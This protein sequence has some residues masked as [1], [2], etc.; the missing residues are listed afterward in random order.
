MIVYSRRRGRKLI[1]MSFL[2]VFKKDSRAVPGSRLSQRGKH[3]MNFVSGYGNGISNGCVRE[4]YIDLKEPHRIWKPE[5]YITG[6]TVVSIKKDVTN[7]A[8]RLI[9]IC[10]IK[11]KLGSTAAVR[12]KLGERLL[13]KST[14]LYGKEWDQD[15]NATVINGLTKGEH[16][17]P[18]RIK[19]PS[20]RKVCSSIKF[21]R[22]SIDYY[23]KCSIENIESNQ[24]ERPISVCE[25]GFSVIVPRDVSLLPKPKVKTVVLQSAAMVRHASKTLG[26]GSSSSFTKATKSSTNS[27]SS[28]NT[29]GS[30]S[31]IDKTVTI[32]VDIS[33]AGFAIGEIIPV[34]VFVQHY[35]NFCR[36][37]GLII[38]LA[39]ICRVSGGGKDEP[40]ETF[41]KDICQTISPLYVDPET[42]Q[43]SVTAY[44]KVPI[45]AFS[46]FTTCH[47]Y[48]TFQYYVEV[49][50]NLSQKNVIYT[51]SKR[52]VG[53]KDT[54]VSEIASDLDDKASF[55]KLP[56][57]FF[58]AVNSD[59]TLN[60]ENSIESNISYQD[61]V[62]VEKLKR[63]NNVTGMSIETVIG[64]TGSKLE[65]LPPRVEYETLSGAIEAT[66][67]LESPLTSTAASPDRSATDWLAP[68]YAYDKYPP[69]P[70]Y[71]P[72]ESISAAVDDKKELEHARL[73][74]L[75]SDP[76]T[77]NF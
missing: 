45:D 43:C 32:S 19:V 57:K 21:E 34:K 59:R 69:A 51:E 13:E 40:M 3:S 70:Q 47:K 14:F 73:K 46:T 6:E 72:N 1:S 63:L 12:R 23:L 50:V 39:R 38:T 74:Q 30:I 71:T 7:V 36:P 44:L 25:S 29:S 65:E 35:K 2:S 27:N 48:F 77:E 61:M 68:L 58:N 15:S 9:L 28:A 64:T 33:N 5:E 67:D 37:A 55:S 54:I 24:V 16:R 20:G 11:V 76:P 18:F 17:F 49:M 56:R 41:R 26:D 10:E 60:D 22:G 42:L 31:S 53:T 4:F 66:D 62:N 75:E 8:I 52:V